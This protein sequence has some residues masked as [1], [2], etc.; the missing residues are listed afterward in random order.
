MHDK[1]INVGGQRKQISDDH[2]ERNPGGAVA[3]VRVEVCCCIVYHK[4]VYGSQG[5]M[6]WAILI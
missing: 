3:N 4:T 1:Y 5:N 2:S 6:V